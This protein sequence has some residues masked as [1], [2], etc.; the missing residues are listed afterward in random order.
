MIGSEHWVLFS[1][2]VYR[3]SLSEWPVGWVGLL[4]MLRADMGNRIMC[5]VHATVNMWSSGSPGAHHRRPLRNLH[6]G[7]RAKC[8][9]V[10]RWRRKQNNWAFRKPLSP[11]DKDGGW[12]H[13]PHLKKAF[14]ET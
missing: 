10:T 14:I 3:V 6:S 5:K 1:W 13:P 11:A 7:C 2:K 4:T 9:K 8:L 12:R